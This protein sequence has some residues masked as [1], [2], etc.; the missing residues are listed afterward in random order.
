MANLKNITDV[1]VVESA[2]GLNLIVNDNGAAK[3]IAASAVGAQADWNVEDTSSPTYIKNKPI[4]PEG[5]NDLSDKPF[6]S[7]GMRV[8]ECLPPTIFQNG[9]P[10]ETEVYYDCSELN[11]N[12]INMTGAD[13]TNQTEFII[14]INGTEYCYPITYWEEGVSY[15]GPT[16]YDTTEDFP[17][18]FD[19]F[20][21][22]SASS[23]PHHIRGF[24]LHPSINL[25]ENVVSVY[26]KELVEDIKPLE[27]KYSQDYTMVFDMEGGNGTLKYISEG[28]YNAIKSLLLE[29][30]PA[31]LKIAAVSGNGVW[32]YTDNSLWLNEN[33]SIEG[34][35]SSGQYYHIWI[36]PDNTAE[37]YYDN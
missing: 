29:F 35:S 21:D 7:K 25:E 17:L 10:S 36:H 18:N 14:N 20:I 1:P 32:Y 9:E 28:T 13:I 5:W 6:Y 26:R 33:K 24:Y 8:V 37:F 4:I 3:Q 15:I 22:S 30:I 27:G 19:F 16:P 23:K 2:E 31:N 12:F 34:W 11:L